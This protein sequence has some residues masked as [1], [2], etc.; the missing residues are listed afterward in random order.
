[1]SQLTNPYLAVI[2]APLA[3]FLTLVFLRTDP[4]MI[5][6]WGRFYAFAM[7]GY[8]GSRYVGRAPIL[9][10]SRNTT[11]EARNVIGWA[12]VVVGFM[13]QIAYGWIFIAYDRPVWLSSQYWGAAFVILICVGLSIVASSVPRF[14]PYGDGR[15]GL[16]EIA[17]IL[18]VI[19]SSL[20]VFAASHIPQLLA[21]I[22]SAWL[23]LAAAF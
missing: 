19:G 7:L 15:N 23:G 10:W 4:D 16:S 5:S 13:M 20:S 11:P 3:V 14:P 17:S 6:L 8:V 9:V 2:L 12:V 1:M 22:K 21:A 18:V